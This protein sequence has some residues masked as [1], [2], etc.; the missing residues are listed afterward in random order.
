MHAI[1]T[2]PIALNLPFAGVMNYEKSYFVSSFG[3]NVAIRNNR[4]ALRCSHCFVHPTITT[5]V[6]S[7]PFWVIEKLRNRISL[8]FGFSSFYC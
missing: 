6:E 8:L 7:A 3:D 4:T 5:F 2:R 1:D